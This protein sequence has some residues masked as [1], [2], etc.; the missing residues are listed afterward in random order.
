MNLTVTEIAKALKNNIS[1]E[2]IVKRVSIDSRDVDSNTLFFAIAGERFDGHDFISQV[3]EKGVAAVVSHKNIQCS[4]PLILVEDTKQAF[5]DF[6]NYY[7]NSFPELL[8]VGLTGSVG[9]TT[10]KEMTACVLSQRFKTLKTEGNLNNE[11]GMPKTIFRLDESF[12]GAVIE[13]GMD[14]AG[15]IAALSRS[16]QPS[17]AIITNVGVSHIENLGS[18]EGILKA[19]LEILQ[20][21]PKGAPVFLNGDN[22]KLATVKNDNYNLI[23]FGI[24]NQD[25]QIRA[26]E[27]KENNLQTEF[28]AVAEGVS[29]KITIPT[30]GIHNVYD[31]LSAFAVGLYYGVEPEKIA[32]G[33]KNYEPSGMR[34]R[35]KEINGMTF[36]EDCYNASP[37]SQKAGLNSLCK[38]A[39]GRKIAVLGDMLELGSYS[40][41]AHRSVGDYAGECGVD[42]LFTFGEQSKYMAENAVK[43]G[44]SR[45]L[46]FAD[47]AE[48]TQSLKNYLKKGDTVLF[49]ASRGMKLEEIFQELYKMWE[50]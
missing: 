10:T 19:K 26:T 9:K 3:A 25:C 36:I 18:R 34:Q 32:E 43:S 27:I 46:S 50:D 41:T 35:I 30:V 1:C 11:I 39:K 48:I 23:F 44:V 2:K 49:K 40:E 47:K 4:V 17:C 31:A 22:D 14:Q 28:V 13:M 6:A 5:L 29:Q 8:V 33:L 16:C 37:D 21:L 15:Q 7:R 38:I 24:E 42:M 12:G 20:G 45:V